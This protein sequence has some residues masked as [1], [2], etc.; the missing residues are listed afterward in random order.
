[1]NKK[2]KEFIKEINLLRLNNFSQQILERNDKENINDFIE[3]LKDNKHKIDY[4]LFKDIIKRHT[5][6]GRLRLLQIKNKLII[7]YSNI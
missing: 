1:L 3:G 7:E 6:N 5:S 2:T 4:K